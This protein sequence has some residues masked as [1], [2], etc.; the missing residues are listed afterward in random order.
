[1]ANKTKVAKKKVASN[2][3]DGFNPVREAPQNRALSFSNVIKSV[4]SKAQF[5]ILYGE[6]PEWAI[7]RREGPGGR[8]LRY[9]PHGYTR[10]QLNKAFGLDWDWELLPCFGGMPFYQVDR[11]EKGKVKQYLTVIGKL[12]IRIHDP[13]KIRDVLT[14]IT[15]TGTGSSL[16]NEGVEFGDALKSADSDAL[17]RAG[18]ALGIALDLYYNEDTAIEKFKQSEKEKQ[19]AEQ[20]AKVLTDENIAK[21]KEMA[22]AGAMPNEIE[23]ATGITPAQ[24]AKLGL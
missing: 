2:N 12:T 8:M 21:A 23:Q 13:E 11:T 24:Q 17:K 14:V 10:D 5:E 3:G 16:W 1:M 20:E 9:V 7:K 19:Q 15:K 6:T 18:L 4:V 22:E